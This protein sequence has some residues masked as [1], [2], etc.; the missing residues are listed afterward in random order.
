MKKLILQKPLNKGG[1]LYQVG[2]EV[3]LEDDTWDWLNNQYIQERID[4]AK[5]LK[6]IQQEIEKFANLNK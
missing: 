4:E 5:K 6:E 1:V 3:E 2:E